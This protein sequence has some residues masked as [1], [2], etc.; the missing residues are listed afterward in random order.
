MASAQGTDLLKFKQSIWMGEKA[1]ISVKVAWLL[2]PDELVWAFHKLQMLWDALLILEARGLWSGCFE[3]IGRQQTHMTSFTIKLGE[4]KF[5][6][7]LLSTGAFIVL[8]WS[9]HWPDL[10]P[11]IYFW[12]VVEPKIS[13][14]DVHQTNLLW[15]CMEQN[16]WR[17]FPAL[18]WN[19]VTKN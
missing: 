5:F 2:V 19:F 9:P 16:L 6:W 12:D 14:M 1:N 11:V 15:C 3:I 7:W 8:K 4:Y 10:T 17:V 13:T 18:C